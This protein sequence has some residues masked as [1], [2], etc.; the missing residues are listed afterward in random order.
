MKPANRFLD[1][2]CDMAHEI[3]KNYIL[4]PVPQ[5]DYSHPPPLFTSETPQQGVNP[6]PI[7][8][9]PQNSPLPPA[10]VKSIG[11]SVR[12]ISPSVIEAMGFSHHMAASAHEFYMKLLEVYGGT[13]AWKTMKI[14]EL[15]RIYMSRT[16]GY[17][18]FRN[19]HQSSS[20]IQ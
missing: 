8:S 20:P 15:F 1:H 11:R 12:F 10:V 4:L 13:S 17:S 6:I 7:R 19:S 14:A 18:F 16:T 3:S 2:F 9:P 5:P